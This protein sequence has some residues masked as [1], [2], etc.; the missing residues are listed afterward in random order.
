MTFKGTITGISADFMTDKGTITLQTDKHNLNALSD[1]KGDLDIQID[2]H[3]EK[4]SLNANAYCWKL[5]TEIANVLTLQGS[6]ITKDDVYFK[7]L[8]DYGQSDIVTILPKVKPDDYFKYYEKM[9]EGEING[10]RYIAYRVYKGSSEYNTREMS[11]LLEGIIADAE[12]LG[13]HTITPKEA[14]EMKARWG[15]EV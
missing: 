15:V 8:K 2:K 11:V 13:I 10:K 5:C 14:E 12:E 6:V 4:R 7:A 1:L 3:R 9:G